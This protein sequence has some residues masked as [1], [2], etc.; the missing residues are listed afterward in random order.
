M[1][2]VG[3]TLMNGAKQARLHVD[4]SVRDTNIQ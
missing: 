4:P 1:Q 3:T 2:P